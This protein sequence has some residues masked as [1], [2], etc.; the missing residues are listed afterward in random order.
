MIYFNDKSGLLVFPTGACTGPWAL[1]WP[2]GF[3]L[4]PAYQCQRRGRLVKE[5]KTE[6]FH[7]EV[8]EGRRQGA[9][10][11]RYMYVCVRENRVGGMGDL[12]SSLTVQLQHFN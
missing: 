7:F 11:G 4:M 3:S 8:A 10:G 9:E 6:E 1:Q 2:P 12:S 5:E